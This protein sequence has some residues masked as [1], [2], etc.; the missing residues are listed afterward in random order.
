MPGLLAAGSKGVI[1]RSDDGGATWR[2]LATATAVDLRDVAFS[3]PTLG[4]ALGANGTLQTTGNG[5][6]SWTTLDPGP[7]GPAEALLTAGNNVLLIGPRGV[8]VATAGGRF[9]PVS[10]PA[11]MKAALSGGGAIGTT[12][13]AFGTRTI[14][15]SSNAGVSWSPVKLP[16]T[17]SGHRKR[18]VSIRDASF[19][20]AT[21]GFVL[22]GAGRLW[23]TQ[24]RGRSWK[25]ISSTGTADGL[26]VSFA[27]PA[28]GFL[29][30]AGFG[31]SSG[32]AFLLRTSDG[33]Q[34]WRP[35]LISSGVVGAGGVASPSAGDAYALVLAPGASPPSGRSLFF[36]HTGGDAGQPSQLAIATPRAR[37]S[38]PQL[39]KAKGQVT[40]T[41]TLAG[42]TGGEQIVV[43]RRDR[44][45]GA[46][47]H[48][49]VTAGANGGS[50]TARFAVKR[51]SL[52]VAQWA[53]DSGRQSAGTRILT[54]RVG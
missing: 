34:T 28:S 47:E 14:L 51:S 30:V 5:G 10:S 49:L 20:S 52:F 35:Q 43:S 21:S 32:E 16:A 29:S 18:P 9:T 53:G 38:R 25:E 17:R 1:A 36:T 33:G 40:I 26:G 24:S 45:G 6:T 50:F 19:T 27:N 23:A 44:N 15:T 46:W 39:R 31:G 42:A 22:D 7:G 8:R 48:K 41:G 2:S 12:V 13:F 54:V 3:S 37:L 4:Y 11:V